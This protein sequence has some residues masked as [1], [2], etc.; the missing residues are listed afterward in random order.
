MSGAI[1]TFWGT[2]SLASTNHGTAKAAQASHF[3]RVQLNDRHLDQKFVYKGRLV[4]SF[5]RH[6]RTAGPVA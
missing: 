1:V 5:C 2:M 3:K 6:T 4:A